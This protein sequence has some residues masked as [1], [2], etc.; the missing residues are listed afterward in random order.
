MRFLP[1]ATL[2]DGCRVFDAVSGPKA[3]KNFDRVGHASYVSTHASEWRTTVE[4]FL[5]SVEK[6]DLS[7]AVQ[8]SR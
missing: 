7:G 3:F 1:R 5:E 6:S 2:T 8:R 4:T